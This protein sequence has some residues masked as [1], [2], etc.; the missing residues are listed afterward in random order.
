MKI[1]ISA[2]L[3]RQHFSKYVLSEAYALSCSDLLKSKFSLRSPR[4]FLCWNW[5]NTQHFKSSKASELKFLLFMWRQVPL[6]AHGVI[7]SHTLIHPQEYRVWRWYFP[8]CLFLFPCHPPNST[9]SAALPTLVFHD[10]WLSVSKNGV[11]KYICKLWKYTCISDIGM[12]N[13]HLVRVQGPWNYE[14]FIIPLNNLAL[15]S[16]YGSLIRYWP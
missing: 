7:F 2:F 11:S 4:K 3:S 12:C 6:L 10:S 1:T 8:S 16:V 15:C 9:E 13:I 5:Q 14:L